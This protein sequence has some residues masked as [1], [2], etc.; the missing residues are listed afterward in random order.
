R[1]TQDLEQLAHEINDTLWSLIEGQRKRDQDIAADM[2]RAER[3]AVLGQVAAGLTHE[4][5]NPLS[6]VIAALDLLRSEDHDNDEVYEQMLDELRRVT[7]TV[8][9]L[10]RLGKPQ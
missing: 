2:A 7:G 9:S 6:G 10:L 3:L 5:K 1:K 8:D 4:I